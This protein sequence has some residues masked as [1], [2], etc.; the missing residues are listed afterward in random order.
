MCRAAGEFTGGPVFQVHPHPYCLAVADSYHNGLISARDAARWAKQAVMALPS[1]AL[2]KREAV[3]AHRQVRGKGLVIPHVERGDYR[4][5]VPIVDADG[6]V[7]FLVTL[8]REDR[9]RPAWSCRA[10][11]AAQ[12]GTLGRERPWAGIVSGSKQ[13]AE[14]CDGLADGD[15]KPVAPPG[16]ERGGSRKEYQGH[17]PPGP[18]A[19]PFG[20]AVE[21]RKGI[22]PAWG[23]V[24]LQPGFPV[25]VE[26]VPVLKAHLGFSKSQDA[27]Y[28]RG[29]GDG[30]RIEASWLE[31]AGAAAPDFSNVC[32]AT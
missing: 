19:W 26:P 2:G 3:G 17:K 27:P 28:G 11:Q 6:K 14:R 30:E 5:R 21:G 4:P 32:V 7:Q 16:S 31:M 20:P 22:M 15:L 12:L 23:D 1:P 9:Q 18:A 8:R 25:G 13:D 24:L 29:D 10:G